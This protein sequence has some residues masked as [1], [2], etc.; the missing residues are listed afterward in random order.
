MREGGAFEIGKKTSTCFF[1][2]TK[3]T[4]SM[5]LNEVIKLQA[6]VFRFSLIYNLS[7]V[8]FITCG[9]GYIFGCLLCLRWCGKTIFV[10]RPLTYVSLSVKHSRRFC[11]SAL[12]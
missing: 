2:F 5:S 6:Q 12:M 4:F 10:T 8:F 9:I 11:I 1:E 7:S 3:E